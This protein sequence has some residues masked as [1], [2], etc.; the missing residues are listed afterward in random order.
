MRPFSKRRTLRTALVAYT[1]G[2]L[3]VFAPVETYLIFSTVG[4][5]ALVT[6]GYIMSVVGM[7]LMLW[8]AVSARRL[9]AV[10]PGLLASGW[11]WTAAIFWHAASGAFRW[12]Y[13]DGALN[14]RNLELWLTPLLATLA[15]IG[16][17]GSLVLLFSPPEEREAS[18]VA[19]G[20]Q[21]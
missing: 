8:G 1:L 5:R 19:D 18:R 15:V 16:M 9:Q 14:G 2:W 3:I 7:G 10:A 17:V 13:E 4:L 12:A 21:P 6:D 20:N 11:S